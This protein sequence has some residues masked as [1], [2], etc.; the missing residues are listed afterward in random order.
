MKKTP[1]KKLA[2][3]IE[4][5]P[6]GSWF[7]CNDLNDNDALDF[8]KNFFMPTKKEASRYKMWLDYTEK[9]SGPWMTTKGSNQYLDNLDRITALLFADQL[10]KDE[11]NHSYV[12]K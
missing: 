10:W 8:F 6:N 5:Y 3:R 11:A 4:K 7:C 12:R 2:G 9:N 1:F